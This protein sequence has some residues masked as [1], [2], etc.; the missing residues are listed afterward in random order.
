MTSKNSL[1]GVWLIVVA[2][3]LCAVLAAIILPRFAGAAPVDL[4]PRPVP[5]PPPG[6]EEPSE[7]G[8]SG[9]P[10][11][12]HSRSNP[13]KGAPVTL[14]VQFSEDWPEKGIQWQE[15]WTVVQWQDQWG[16]WHDVDGWQGTLDKVYLDDGKVMG[17]KMWWLYDS[18][19]GAGPFRWAV[20]AGRTGK[21]M[22]KTDPFYL[23]TSEVQK[24]TVELQLSP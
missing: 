8:P 10:A 6:G 9:Q 11:A 13:V 18:L 16:Y 22:A 19:L 21:V 5:Q 12:S 1:S 14:K 15:L 17:A 24:L 7:P 2:G 23:P 20:F 4:P 3:A